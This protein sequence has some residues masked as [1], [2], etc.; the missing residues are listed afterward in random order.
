MLRRYYIGDFAHKVVGLGWVGAE[1]FV[2]L[3]G[4]RAAGRWPAGTPA[5]AGRR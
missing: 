2:L 5:P 3:L 4:D 1:A